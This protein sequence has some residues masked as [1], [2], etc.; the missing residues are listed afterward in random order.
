MRNNYL[1]KSRFKLALNCVTQLYYTGKKD[2]YADKNLDDDFL[3][4][5]AKGGFQVGELA[6]YYFC[7][8]PVKEKIT[9]DFILV[10]VVGLP[11]LLIYS[12]RPSGKPQ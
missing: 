7:D 8:D 12:V 10:L 9:I 11:K 2:V 4:A 5:L 6:K 3:E 1:T